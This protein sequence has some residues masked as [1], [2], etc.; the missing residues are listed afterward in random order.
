MNALTS[1]IPL[2]LTVT[3]EW[4]VL[5]LQ[6]VG[7]EVDLERLNVKVIPPF[8]IFSNQCY[9]EYHMRIVANWVSN[10]KDR[11]LI[12]GLSTQ[13]ALEIVNVCRCY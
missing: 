9:N 3:R 11:L 13:R 2:Q 5:I 1:S 4:R 10:L 7:A 8:S 6:S 12:V